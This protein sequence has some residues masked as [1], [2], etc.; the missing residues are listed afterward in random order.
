MAFWLVV[1]FYGATNL[2]TY[3]QKLSGKTLFANEKSALRV[4]EDRSFWEEVH[5]TGI[6]PPKVSSASSP[7]YNVRFLGPHN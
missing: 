6:T 1:L 5:E 4:S 3:A 2:P 7:L